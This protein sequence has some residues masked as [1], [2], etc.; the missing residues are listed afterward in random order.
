MPPDAGVCPTPSMSSQAHPDQT[1]TASRGTTMKNE[2]CSTYRGFAVTTRSVEVAPVS[3]WTPLSALT[4]TWS[5]RF[6]ASFSVDPDDVHSDS[7]QQFPTARFDTHGRAT[8]NALSEAHRS[9][10][11]KMGEI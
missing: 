1:E 10:D 4:S 7:W 8:A 3:D 9:I 11:M 5:R 6:T 2:C